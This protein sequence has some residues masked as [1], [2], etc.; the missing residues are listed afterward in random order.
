MIYCV[1]SILAWL[2]GYGCHDS[3][4]L[5]LRLSYNNLQLHRC[6]AI[7]P[8]IHYSNIPI[9]QK[10]SHWT[11]RPFVQQP[12]ILEINYHSSEGPL[13]QKYTVQYF[14]TYITRHNHDSNGHL[15]SSFTAHSNTPITGIECIFGAVGFCFRD[16]RLLEQQEVHTSSS[17]ES[18]RSTDKEKKAVQRRAL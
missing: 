15:T 4:C 1:C 13:I 18:K 10:M 2:A 17:L 3:V 16:N 9:I 7:V 14:L 8:T 12:V 11:G 5:S 6:H